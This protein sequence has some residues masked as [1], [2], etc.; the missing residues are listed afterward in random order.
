MGYNNS[1]FTRQKASNLQPSWH[2]EPY[3]DL[4]PE[5]V[6]DITC[7]QTLSKSVQIQTSN[8]TPQVDIEGDE[9]GN[10]V[11]HTY[12]DTEDTVWSEE[13][14]NNEHYTP[15]ELLGL[16]KQFLEE[17]LL[18]GI[19]FK[20]PHFTRHLIEEC[21]EWNEDEVEFIEE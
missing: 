18:H 19:V 13:Y 6:F 5:E 8:Y 21:N 1:I 10:T 15:L 17:Q 16:F 3:E 20:N 11:T 12:N 2:E 4:T 7:V 9:D 14:R